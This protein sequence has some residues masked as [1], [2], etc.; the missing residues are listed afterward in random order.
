[1]DSVKISVEISG[2][3]ADGT[4]ISWAQ[5]GAFPCTGYVG[6]WEIDVPDSGIKISS[7]NENPAHLAV[8]VNT[9]SNDLYVENEDSNGIA[10]NIAVPAGAFVIVP[11]MNDGS[12]TYV[13][14]NM[15]LYSYTSTT[16]TARYFFF[17]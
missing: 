14:A 13:L 8:I 16:T 1:M 6:G 3:T 4:A 10:R 5:G 15:T 12:S 7:D 11:L 9:G 2:S 17:Y